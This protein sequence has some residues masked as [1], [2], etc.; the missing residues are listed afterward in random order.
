MSVFW[1]PG[2]GPPKLAIAFSSLKFPPLH[3]LP[4]VV[5]SLYPSTLLAVAK[6]H[7]LTISLVTV[8]EMHLPLMLFSLH[9][10]ALG[11]ISGIFVVG[12]PDGAFGI[13]LAR[14]RGL[15]T[16]LVHGIVRWRAGSTRFHLAARR[17]IVVHFRLTARSR[18]TLM[19]SSWL[20]PRLIHRWWWWSSAVFLRSAIPLN[21]GCR[22]HAL[23][24]GYGTIPRISR[25]RPHVVWSLMIWGLGSTVLLIFARVHPRRGVNWTRV[26]G[27]C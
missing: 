24:G 19:H 21:L 5:S 3:L 15:F 18:R 22:I 17:H 23:G 25:I 1:M 6:F 14:R 4:L 27:T 8:T 12:H 2:R 26:V 16:S 11:Q 10:L 20:P 7:L 13:I 9:S